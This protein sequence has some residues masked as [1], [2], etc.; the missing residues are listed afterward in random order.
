MMKS[1]KFN[2]RLLMLA[3]VVLLLSSLTPQTLLAQTVG[4][5]PVALS[6]GIPTGTPPPLIFTLS[7]TVSI[8]G[9]GPVTLSNFTVTP[10]PGDFAFN[11][12][13]CTTP[14]TAP[15]TCEIGVQFTSTEP[16]GTLETAPP[17]FNSTTQTSL[18]TVPLNGAYGA[19]KL[20]GPID[21][22][23]SLISYVTWTQNPPSAG[24]TVQ[25][26]NINLSCPAGVT[27][28]LSSTPDGSGNVFQDN[29][30]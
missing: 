22:D 17:S 16:A 15:T 28:S 12:N 3:V 8:T 7:V 14:Q 1:L 30:I 29:T 19:I 27:A 11:G 26:A 13:S 21:V 23:R 20:F 6:F 25:S 10:T 5:S 2:V 24:Y 9:T 18:I 4:V